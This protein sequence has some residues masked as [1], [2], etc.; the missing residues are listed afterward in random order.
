MTPLF[1]HH[2]LFKN[3]GTTIDE[4]LKREL[5]SGWV[6]IEPERGRSRVAADDINALLRSNPE[7]RAISSHHL[8]FEKLVY[9]DRWLIDVVVLRHPL[10]RFASMYRYYRRIS[11]GSVFSVIALRESLGGFCMELTRRF[12]CMM[13]D[14]QCATLG[15]EGFWYFPP[16]HETYERASSVLRSASVLLSVESLSCGLCIAE[17]FLRQ[18]LPELNLAYVPMN[19]TKPSDPD[20]QRVLSDLKAEMGGAT[21]D[22]LLERN[23]LDLK[24]WEFTRIEVNRRRSCVLECDTLLQNFGARC[25]ALAAESR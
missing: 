6:N 14:A 8:G 13:F 19:V 11:D 7:I 21:W 3:A 12:P 2:H 5:G 22:Y 25:V 18:I 15:N 10:D 9:P 16:N 20:F 17:F 23:Q 1:L 4:V 24:L